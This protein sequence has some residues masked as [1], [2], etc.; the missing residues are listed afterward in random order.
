MLSPWELERQ[1]LEREESKRVLLELKS[2]LGIRTSDGERD[3]RKR[4]LFNEQGTTPIDLITY[5]TTYLFTSVPFCNNMEISCNQAVVNE[6]TVFFSLAALAPLS[7]DTADETD[8]NSIQPCVSAEPTTGNHISQQSQRQLITEEEENDTENQTEIISEVEAEKYLVTE[9]SCGDSEVT[10]A[11]E[12]ICGAVETQLFQSDGLIDDGT[13][14]L[15][16]RVPT[17]SVIDRLT[18]MHGSET[19]S[20]SSALAAQVAARSHTF[21]HMQECT[22]GDSEEDEEAGED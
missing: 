6:L 9:F 21:T 3:K 10:G 19:I 7:K 14:P 2:V 5:I 17:L 22:Y 13:H 18:E 16:P 20:F 15:T 1:R 12:D 4:L 11:T 8:T